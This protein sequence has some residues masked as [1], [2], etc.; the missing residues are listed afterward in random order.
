MTRLPVVDLARIDVR[1]GD[2]F[3]VRL[4]ATAS[5]SH[6]EVLR[7]KW[8]TLFPDNDVLIVAGVDEVA[9][10]RDETHPAAR[11]TRDGD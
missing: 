11:A 4:P 5:L 8:Q 6:A 2:V 9:V 1:P 7:A 10:L 3:L